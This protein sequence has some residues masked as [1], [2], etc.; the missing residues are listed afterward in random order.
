MKKNVL[1]T[2]V[3]TGIGFDAARTLIARGF[4]VFGSVRKQADADRVS[5]ELGKDFTPLLFDVTDSKAIAAAAEKVHAMVGDHGLAALVNNS[6]I[7]P[8]G[9]L[10]HFPLDEL[11]NLLEVNVIGQLAVTQ[12]FLLLLGARKNCPHPPGRIVYISSISGGV[13]FPFTAAYAVSKHALESLS[14]GLRRELCIYGIEVSAIE[15]GVIRTPIWDK[16]G[17]AKLDERYAT[18]DYADSLRKLPAI[19]AEE[20][21]KGDPVEKVTRAIVTAIE[22]QQPKTRYP[23]SSLWWVA[24]VLSDRMLDRLL[25]KQMGP[26]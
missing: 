16:A 4:H 24:K 11:R 22:S 6:G 10:M 25:R 15:P 21:R 9:P 26:I 17:E 12:A 19:L 7:A 5:A 13:T 3:S 20:V 14:D 8:G 1:I 18:T 2:G 23:L